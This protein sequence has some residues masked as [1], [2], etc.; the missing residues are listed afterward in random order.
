MS[1]YDLE[2]KKAK[3]FLSIFAIIVS[4]L[5]A[6]FWS[7]YYLKYGMAPE[8]RDMRVLFA[9]EKHCLVIFSLPFGISRWW[10]IFLGPLWAYFL[11]CVWKQYEEQEALKYSWRDENDAMAGLCMFGFLFGFEGFLNF[12]SDGTT[13]VCFSMMIIWVSWGLNFGGLKFINPI[14]V[15]IFVSIGI[16]LSSGI[17]K[18]S[19]VLLVLNLVPFVCLGILKYTWMGLATIGKHSWKHFYSAK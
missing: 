15:S 2:L 4:A 7:W 10:D 11:L 14:L 18:G 9:D 6:F 8:I 19:F 16:M 13:F 3:R 12:F 1:K 17:A 5:I